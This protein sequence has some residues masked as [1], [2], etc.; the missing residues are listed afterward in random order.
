M[1]IPAAV[2]E[3]GGGAAVEGAGD[4]GGAADDGGADVVATTI[5]NIYRNKKFLILQIMGKYCIN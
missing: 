5:E 4:D 2:G 3:T 1:F